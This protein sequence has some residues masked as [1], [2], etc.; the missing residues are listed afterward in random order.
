MGSEQ[1]SDVEE[2]G[3]HTTTSSTDVRINPFKDESQLDE[4]MALIDSELSEPYTIYTY[5]YFIH[6][7]PSLCFLA[8]TCHESRP[9]G[10]VIGKLDRH[11]K[12]NRYMRGYIGM[13]SVDR[14]HRGKG[15]ATQLLQTALTEMIKQG[16][17]EVCRRGECGEMAL[18]LH[19]L[20]W[21]QRQTIWR[22]FSSMRVWGLYG[23]NVSTITT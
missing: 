21:R 13:L 2:Q 15:I 8:H 1:E 10:V 14:P 4:I 11:L 6:Q 20:F 18:M 7:W 12:G 3:V 19:R 16:A 22:L 17:Q 9:V 5:R 23:R